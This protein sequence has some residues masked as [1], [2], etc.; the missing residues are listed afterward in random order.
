MR[1]LER[2]NLQKLWAENERYGYTIDT[3]DVARRIF[4]NAICKTTNMRLGT[5]FQFLTGKEMENSHQALG[6][7]KALYAIF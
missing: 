7:V 2:Q 1:S 5:L 6:D 3:L 4:Q